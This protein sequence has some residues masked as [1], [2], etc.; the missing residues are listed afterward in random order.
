[1]SVSFSVSFRYK[2]VCHFDNIKL[3]FHLS[4]LQCAATSFTDRYAAIDEVMIH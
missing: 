4:G 3:R 2:I 1:M